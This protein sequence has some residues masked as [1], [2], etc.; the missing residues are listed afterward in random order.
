MESYHQALLRMHLASSAFMPIALGD[1]GVPCEIRDPARIS[2]PAVVH[3]RKTLLA[4]AGVVAFL[5]CT[6]L[7]AYLAEH[8]LAKAAAEAGAEGGSVLQQMEVARTRLAELKAQVHPQADAPVQSAGSLS[9][10]EPIQSFAE[11]IM[12]FSPD[13]TFKVI[14]GQ[15]QTTGSR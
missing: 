4:L 7:G 15:I 8:Y 13:V 1:V 10:P 6:G 5:A 9:M 11:T 3:P 14:H 2:L 12:A